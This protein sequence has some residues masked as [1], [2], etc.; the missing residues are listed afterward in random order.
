MLIGILLLAGFRGWASGMIMSVFRLAGLIAS[1]GIAIIYHGSLA[2]WLHSEWGLAD[3]IASLLKPLV[4]LPGPFNNPEILRMPVNLLQQISAQ[5]PLPPPWP[6]IIQSLGLMSPNQ[7]V[8]QAINLLLAHGILK[9]L[10]FLVLFIGVRFCVDLLGGIISAVIKYSPL[11]P[12]DKAA[13]LLLGL[14]TGVVIIVIIMT[15]MLPL[16]VPL[17][18]LGANGV[19]EGLEG[20][21]AGS[22]LLDRYGPIVEGFG[23][24]P[25][26]LPEFSNQMLFKYLPS[27]SGVEI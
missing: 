15:V 22:V 18:L 9:I 3:T 10:A 1:F 21:L 7:T 16:Q 25:S 27:G 26:I 20:A 5:I 13:G 11:G 24:L 6:E 12:L 8:G 17:A 19:L 4:K 23:V 14:L 2:N